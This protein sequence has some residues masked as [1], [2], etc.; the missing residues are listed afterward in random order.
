MREL[1]RATF[2]T[3]PHPSYVEMTPETVPY[4]QVY[5]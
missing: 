1:L 3:P 4:M 2:W 5:K